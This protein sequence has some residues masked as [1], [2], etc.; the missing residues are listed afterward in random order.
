MIERRSGI[1]RSA[2]PARASARSP[3]SSSRQA[4]PAPGTSTTRPAQTRRRQQQ[5]GQE[6]DRTASAQPRAGTVA[7]IL[8]L[9]GVIQS[10]VS[11]R[12][13]GV[14]L[15]PMTT[16]SPL[17]RDPASISASGSGRIPP[18]SIGTCRSIASRRTLDYG[19]APR[20]GR[21]E[22]RRRTGVGAIPHGAHRRGGETIGRGRRSASPSG[23]RIC[24]ARCRRGSKIG[25]ATSER[26]ATAGQCPAT[27]GAG[28]GSASATTPLGQATARSASR[29]ATRCFVA[30]VISPGRSETTRACRW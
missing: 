13:F 14:V 12:E 18:T 21:P 19:L 9:E 20:Q 4:R 16:D 7:F 27:S 15:L 1:P 23:P 10:L 22:R 3:W 29:G 24:A 25:N 17:R 28:P 2:C 30:K 5:S 26:A 11:S 6:N 8:R